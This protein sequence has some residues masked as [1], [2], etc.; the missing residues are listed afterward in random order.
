NIT[1]FEDWL[2]DAEKFYTNLLG[3]PQFSATIPSYGYTIEILSAQQQEVDS[4]KALQQTQQREMGE[5][6]QATK[7][8]WENFNQL[9][10]WCDH[11]T[12]LAKIEFEDD[13][14]LLE[15]L[16]ILVRS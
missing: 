6:Q 7:D 12:E 13:A 11:L 2:S 1:R 15:K 5:A 10:K 9:K 14:Q 8:K 4:L 3:N 16:G